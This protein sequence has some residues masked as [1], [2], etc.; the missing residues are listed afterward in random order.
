MGTD[1]DS[2][3]MT[4]LKVSVIMPAYNHARY[5]DK[6][7]QSI[8]DQTHKNIELIVINDGS[9][10][11]T[12]PIISAFIHDHPDMT[13]QYCEQQNKGVCQTLNTGL[14]KASGDYIALLASDDYWCPERLAV[15]LEFMENNKNIGMVFSDTWMFKEGSPESYRW[16]DYKSGLDKLFKNGIQ[17]V[18]FY[19]I[20]LTQPLIPA[21][22]VLIRKNVLADVGCF[23]ESLVYEDSD[24]WLRIAMLYPIAYLNRPLAFYRLHEAN[25]SNNAGFM[26]KGMVQT[27]KKHFLIGPYRHNWAKQFTIVVSLAVHLLVNRW[28]KKT[29]RFTT[30]A[31][32]RE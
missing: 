21:L 3:L 4:Q 23:D 11:Q 31:E 20:L 12:G 30:H 28:K 25:V 7:L 18:D 19:R 27:V 29:S 22:T 1:L 9:S 32:K 16:S 2:A 5:I 26:L 10:D 15:Q 17:N 8:A 14:E 13:I 6:A 24:F